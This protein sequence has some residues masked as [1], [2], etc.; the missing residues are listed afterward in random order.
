MDIPNFLVLTKTTVSCLLSNRGLQVEKQ[1][2]FV[3][4]ADMPSGTRRLRTENSPCLIGTS[5]CLVSVDGP[6]SIALLVFWRVFMCS[7]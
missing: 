6:C 7:K 1:V 4:N 3:L 2:V 5:S